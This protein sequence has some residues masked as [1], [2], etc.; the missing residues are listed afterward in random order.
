MT[1]KRIGSLGA[2]PKDHWLKPVGCMTMKEAKALARNPDRLVYYFGRRGKFGAV[3]YEEGSPI[4]EEEPAKEEPRAEEAVPA[5]AMTAGL[6]ASLKQLDLFT[7]G[8]KWQTITP[9]K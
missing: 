4:T 9:A 7:E 2:L 8:Q 3:M 1:I 5:P 6:A